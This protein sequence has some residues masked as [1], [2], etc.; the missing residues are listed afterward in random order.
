[1]LLRVIRQMRVS[2][3]SESSSL[4]EVQSF[5]EKFGAGQGGRES[6]FAGSKA[7]IALGVVA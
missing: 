4:L 2:A 5:R 6:G 1:M 7:E 3:M